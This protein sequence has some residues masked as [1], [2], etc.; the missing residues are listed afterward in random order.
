VAV[1]LRFHGRFL[2][3]KDANDRLQVIAPTFNGSFSPHDTL[4]AIPH[5]E[6]VFV[7]DHDVTRPLT[8]LAPK[9]RIA[10][11]VD[12]L[13][14]QVVVWDLKGL[15]VSYDLEAEVSF[16]KSAMQVLDLLELE[17]IRDPGV[18]TK[19]DATAL[20]ATDSRTNSVIR[21]SAGVGTFT[22]ANPG[23]NFVSSAAVNALAAG[24]PLKMAKQGGGALLSVTPAEVVSFDVPL[25]APALTM[26]F[27]TAAGEEV[28]RVT[29][30]DG[31]VISMSNLCAPIAVPQSSDLEFG[32]YYDLLTPSPG[33]LGLIPHDGTGGSES[34]CCVCAAQVPTPELV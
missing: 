18:T 8:T 4:M 34:A 20:K 10:S 31:A 29:V 11:H 27:S 15:H 12:P 3:V 32:R 28:G 1:T 9:C 7:E 24:Q 14:P 6:I 25:S 26:R 16:A 21:V 22:G 33:S 2:Y 17:A 5:P 30:A 23:V 19:L 13:N